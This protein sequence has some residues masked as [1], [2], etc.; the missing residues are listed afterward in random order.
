MPAKMMKPPIANALFALLIGITGLLCYMG[1]TNGHDWGDDFAGYIMQ[2][3]S[4]VEGR[5]RE[6]IKANRF[7]IEQ[8]SSVGGPVAYP[9]GFPALLAPLYAVYGNNVIALKS[10]GVVC[11]LLFLWVLWLG[12]RK[13]YSDSWRLV[14]VGLFALNPYLLFFTN[15]I[16]SDIPFLLFSTVSLLLLGA[17]VIEKRRLISPIADQLLLGALI[18]ASF[19][20]R[21]NGIA[22]LLTLG[23][24]Q[25]AVALPSV[26]AQRTTDGRG[27]AS[28][29]GVFSQ[30]TVRHLCVLVLPYVTFAILTSVW[31][32]LLPG[33]GSSYF[34]LFRCMSLGLIK[35]HL[36]YYLD[37]PAMFI[38]PTSS[39][40]YLI[41]GAR[42]VYGVTIL[43]AGAGIRK[44]YRS[45]FHMLAYMALTLLLYILWPFEQGI[46][47]LFP[48][49]P[50]YVSF[51]LTGL[52]ELLSSVFGPGKTL[53]KTISVS[54]VI[55][56]LL[57]CTILS[58]RRAFDNL[59]R[60]RDGRYGP[61]IQ[62]SRDMFSFVAEN[63][64]P[65]STI[66]FFKPRAMK[67]MTGRR[68]LMIDRVGELSRG[69]YVCVYLPG[70]GYNQ[71]PPG[72]IERLAAQGG[73]EPVYKNKDF[74]LYRLTKS[75]SRSQ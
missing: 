26:V 1:L 9:W 19:T 39:Y 31:S 75:I 41:H 5:P 42:V 68:S 15:E 48:L 52:E 10:V 37:I 22:L 69:D 38:T 47:F 34:Y 14:M 11:F 49:L 23:I 57:G 55:V 32:T 58:A 33:G 7:T 44:R 35:H 64:D 59:N 24:T 74:A 6:F 43:L 61:Y 8:S 30:T 66:V 72:D 17:V 13:Y 25:L 45:D 12:F 62:T 2:A 4:I 21:T 40:H 36:V 70:N 28:L 3:Q 63:T 46:R 53:W 65:T 54:P 71:V 60:N 67:L 51:V 73:I 29:R 16:L 27:L 18:A 20:I 50:F 56:L